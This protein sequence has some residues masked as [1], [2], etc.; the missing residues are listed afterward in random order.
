MAAVH[1][2]V[3]YLSDPV[4][5]TAQFRGPAAPA[6]HGLLARV[7]GVKNIYTSLIRFYAAYHISNP[8]LYD[9]AIATF[10]GVQVLYASEV[11]VF[12]TARMRECASS[13]VLSGSAIVWMVVQREWYLSQ[14]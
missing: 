8:Q 10:V 11:F 3:C 2:L 6:P 9:L 7:Y 5:S 12:K 4:R 13:F 1:S 14:G